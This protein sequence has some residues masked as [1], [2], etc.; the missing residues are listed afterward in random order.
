VIGLRPKLLLLV[1]G[2]LVGLLLAEAAVR[3]LGFGPPPAPRRVVHAGQSKEWCCGPLIELGPTNRFEPG[4]TF[5][6]CYSGGSRGDFD[7]QGCVPYR[8]NAHGYRGASY[9]REKPAEA[10]RIVLLGDSFTFGEGT[11]EGLIYPTLLGE[12]LRARRADGR[13]IEV[14]NLG[15]PGDG[16]EGAIATYRDSARRLGPDWVV[17]QWNTNDFPS[18]EVRADHLLLIGAR[19]RELFARAEALRRSHLLSFAYMRLQ[20]WLLS[21]ELI[22]TTRQDAER[23]RYR[24]KEIGRLRRMARADGAG[25]TVL[26]FPELI[27]LDAYP[28]ETI[29]ELLH[30][31]C[32]SEGIE[33][34]DLLPALAAH[35]DSEL[36]VHE[37]DHHPNRIAHAIAA[38]ELL[39]RLE[40]LLPA[41]EEGAR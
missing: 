25:F 23:G 1:L 28:Y 22:A 15:I 17:F 18:P 4:S 40:P 19:Y 16:V 32:R 38:R 2:T 5:A 29:L 10:Y 11:P 34:I 8:I 39:E 21:R 13:R 7:A 33:L 12:A 9:A 26:A 27:R 35:R 30:D 24:F 14:I 20:T 37:T 36:W 3:L 6:H 31:Y 41:P